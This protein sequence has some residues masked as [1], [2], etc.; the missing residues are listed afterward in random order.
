M[1]VTNERSHLL[2]LSE[3]C[4]LVAASTCARGAA[5]VSR[6]LCCLHRAGNGSVSFSS[7]R[8]NLAIDAGRNV[9][10][11][12][13]YSAGQQLSHNAGK[14]AAFRQSAP[15]TNQ[16]VQDALNLYS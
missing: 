16:G 4:T 7:G 11:R 9:R 13:G 8:I 1:R 15:L 10:G 5:K 12:A 3:V 6:L 2:P 14:A